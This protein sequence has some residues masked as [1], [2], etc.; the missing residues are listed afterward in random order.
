MSS[1]AINTNY[2][3]NLPRPA[4][5]CRGVIRSWRKRTLLWKSLGRGL[6]EVHAH[7][8]I[9]TSTRPSLGTGAFHG[10]GRLHLGHVGRP[11]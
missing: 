3:R 5:N 8:R 11:T 6:V 7:P 1:L 2:R 4:P 9:D 10:D